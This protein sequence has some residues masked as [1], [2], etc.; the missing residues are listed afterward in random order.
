MPPDPVRFVPPLY[1]SILAAGRLADVTQLNVAV[2]PAVM[3][4]VSVLGVVVK[5]TEVNGTEK[6]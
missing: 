5:V 1:H 3:V 2:E 4:T 6:V